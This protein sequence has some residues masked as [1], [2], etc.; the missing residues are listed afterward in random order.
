[1]GR[2][3]AFH[4]VILGF[5]GRVIFI[6]GLGGSRVHSPVEIQLARNREAQQRF[7]RQKVNFLKVLRLSSQLRMQVLEYVV[8]VAGHLVSCCL[9]QP[10]VQKT[11]RRAVV[12]QKMRWQERLPEGTSAMQI[13]CWRRGKSLQAQRRGREYTEKCCFHTKAQKNNFPWE[14]RA[15]SE[16]SVF[17]C[18]LLICLS[19]NEQKPGR[20]CAGP[21]NA[22]FSRQLRPSGFSAKWFPVTYADL[23]Q[24]P[25]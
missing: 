19:L 10:A 9:E 14:W 25:L 16:V 11:G 2:R 24:Y 3:G 8:S 21:A 13:S 18:C 5:Y 4:T 23:V 15:G 17:I 7:P 20:Q 22:D 6:A 12:S 1:M